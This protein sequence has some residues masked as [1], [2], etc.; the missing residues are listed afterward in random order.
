MMQANELPRFSISGNIVDVV[1]R[2]IFSGILHIGD[3]KII[4]VEKT[5]PSAGPYILPGL[6]DAHIHIESSMLAPSEFARMAV[7]HGTVA[8]VSDPHEIA[9]ILGME[10]IKFMIRNGKTVPFH[11]YF[12]APSCVPATGFET[13]GYILGPAETEE[14]LQNTDILYL[15]EM[16]NFPG[17]V[18]DDPDV[19][20]KLDAA[21]KAGKP[22]DGHAPGLKGDLLAKYVA[23][24]ISTDHECTTVEEAL[25]KIKLG[26][27]ILIREGSAARNF[28][29]LIPLLKEHPDMVMFC[30]DDKHPDDLVDGHLNL[31]LQ[32]AVAAG[33]DLMDA[34]R[35]CTF[36]PVKHYNLNCG[37]LQEGDPADLVIVDS[38]ADFNVL[39]TYV[40]GEKVAESGKSLFAAVEAEKPNR[41]DVPE[42]DASL[43]QVRAEEGLLKVIKAFDGE[44]L[45]EKKLV[46]PRIIGGFVESDVE[47]D[48]LKIVV[49][50]RY[51]A[52]K[53]SVGFISGIGIKRGALASTVAHDSHNLICVGT[54]DREMMRAIQLVSDHKGG[55]AVVDGE[56]SEIL[57]LPIAGI[58]T[59]MEGSKVADSYEM[60][61]KLA[62]ELGS[63]LRAPFM[64]LS[65]MALLVIPQLK[66]SDKG[67]FDG[68]S[69]S[70]TSLFEG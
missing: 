14:L 30:S 32:R 60:I 27:H 23:A 16:M 33:Y 58:M 15:S 12:G 40:K 4:S 50:N 17:V 6:V 64:T 44:L 59:D 51:Q 66:L 29:N 45:T 7:V 24:G 42:I 18:Y 54:S 70:F 46:K 63:P 57:P 68:T 10:G 52:G 20:A 11:F 53:P 28:D 9:N 25:E 36:N 2:T 65:F 1:S 3:G 39:R 8:T 34:L 21:R 38:L 37:L 49:I 35:A 61:N 13:S 55:I 69:F 47:N 22:V 19:H 31:L 41:F 26:M 5:G 43:L 62:H 48:I 56:E 67:L